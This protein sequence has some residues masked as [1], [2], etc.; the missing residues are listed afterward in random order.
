[1]D[2]PHPSRKILRLPNYDYSQNGAYFVTICVEGRSPILSR[3]LVPDVGALPRPA[4][5]P[6]SE[7]VRQLKS[8]SAQRIN[9]LRGTPGTPLWQRGYYEHIIRNRQD[10]EQAVIYIQNNPARWAEKECSL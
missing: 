3:I 7:L 1:M 2:L 9:K 5:T 6:L 10:L 8:F 4:T